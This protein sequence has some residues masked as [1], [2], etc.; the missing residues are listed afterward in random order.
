MFKKI[1]IV[2][3]VLLAA[4]LLFATT[5]P[6][7]FR[8]QRTATIQ[9][10]PE[11]VFALINDFHDWGSWSPWEK[12]DPAMKRTY[13]GAANGKGAAYAWEGNSKVGAGRMEIT[14]TSAP[15]KVTIQ[16][17]FI[18]PFEGHNVAEFTLEPQGGSTKVTWAMYGPSPYITKVMCVFISMDSMI[19]KDFEAGLANLKT[20]AEKN[21][22]ATMTEIK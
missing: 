4:L 13:S 16:L 8:V 22:R 10:P 15:S 14:D 17:D 21:D 5:K 18:K 2:V 6:D 20:V 11:K 12:L 9:A 7:T 3:V 19:G 1:A